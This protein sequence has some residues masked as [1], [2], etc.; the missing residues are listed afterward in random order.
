[1][2]NDKHV[3]VPCK[4]M[5]T[6]RS[7]FSMVAF[8]GS[9]YAIGGVSNGKVLRSVERYTTDS[10]VWTPVEPMLL[11]RSA[12]AAA[13]LNNQIFVLGGAT[14]INSDE[15]ATVEKFDGHS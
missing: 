9:I 4:S 7:L 3:W 12:A 6:A 14:S 13:V 8:G 11:P 15:T 2:E 5:I 10:D 1:M